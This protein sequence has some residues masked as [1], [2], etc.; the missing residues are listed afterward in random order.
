MHK[1]ALTLLVGTTTLLASLRG[2]AETNSVEQRLRDT[3]T[4][5]STH[6]SR[7]AG[8]P[9]DRFAADLVEREL[10]A[11]GVEG[12]RREPYE[13]VVPIDHGASLQVLREEGGSDGGDQFELKSLWP[14][15]VRT[16]TLGPQGL[17]GELIYAG[18]GEYVDFN[19][20]NVQGSVV[21]MEFNSGSNWK[22][23]AA[24]GAA[25]IIFVEPGAT[26][27]VESRKKWSWAPVD[28]PRFWIDGDAATALRQRMRGADG[29]RVHLQAR[30]DWESVTTWNIWGQVPGTDPALAD[31]LVAVQASYDG[32]S[33]VPADNPA[34][35]SA[36]SIAALLEFA[37]Y[38][39]DHPPG[40]SV[41]LLATGSNFLGK[42]GVFEFFDRHA[43]MEPLFKNRVPKRLVVDKIDTRRLTAAAQVRGLDLDSLGVF[44]GNAREPGAGPA[45]ESVDI[46][47]LTAQLK[48]RRLDPDSLGVPL[49][50]DSLAIA[51]FIGLDLSSHGS[52]VGLLQSTW[53]PELRRIFVPLGRSFTRYAEAFGAGRAGLI[54]LISP[55]KGLTAASYIAVDAGD[56]GAAARDVGI[57]ALNLVTTTDAR[58]VLDT[59]LDTHDKVDFNYLGRQSETINGVLHRALAD[60]ALF[61][62]RAAENRRSHEKNLPD[63]R[64]AIDGRLRL[65]PIRGATPDDPVPEA[66]VSV[67]DDVQARVWRPSLYLADEE[68][69]YQIGARNFSTE[70][71]GFL[72]DKTTGDIVYATDMGERAQD[73]GAYK[74]TPS[75]EATVWMTILFPVESMEIHERI[76]A[77]RH[78]TFGRWDDDTKILDQRGGKPRQYGFGVGTWGEQ[79]LVLFGAR[80]DSLR[81]VEQSLFLLDNE[82]A[83][84]EIEA[85]GRGFDLS[86]HKMLPHASL[87]SAVD[88]WRIDE[89]RIERMRKFAIEN[90][91]V[92]A[93]HE[94][95]RVAL[96]RAV[97]AM[98]ALDWGLYIKYIREALGYEYRAYPDV[99]GTQS[100]VMNGLVFF[101]ALLIPAA[102]FSERLIFASTDIRRQLALC[103]LITLIVWIILAQVHPAFGLAHPI[104][105][106]LAL[107]VLGTALFVMSLIA[108]RFNGFMDEL[109]ES[110]TGTV[111]GDI[112]RAGT[113]YA[114]FM[115]GISNMRRRAL[116]TCLT[117]GTITILTFTVLSFTSAKQA[118]R[119]VGFEKD[120]KPAYAGVLVHDVHWWPLEPTNLAFLASHFGEHGTIAARSWLSMGWRQG[121]G[122]MPIRRGDLEAQAL[123]VM[124]LTAIE[125]AL[126]GLD[127]ALTA[128]TWFGG[129]AQDEGIMLSNHLAEQLGIRSE[130]IDGDAERADAP[131]VS[132]L[133]RSWTVVGLFDG[134]IYDS[135]RDLNNEPITPAKQRFEQFNLPGMDRLLAS[136]NLYSAANIDIGVEHMPA[137]RLAILPFDRMTEMGVALSSVAIALN[138]PN[139]ARELVESYLARAAFRLFVAFPDDEGQQHTYAYTS[140]S[141]TGM[142]GFG[143]L[144]I[145]LL[146]A[147]LIVLNTMM[148]AVYERFREIGVYSS[149]G[150]APVHIA[151]LFIAE[152]CVYGILGITLGYIVGQVGAKLLMAYDL[153]SGVSLNYSSTSAIAAAVLVMVVVVASTLYPAKVA[154]RMAVPDV[155][156]RWQLPDPEEDIWQFDF[157]F[158]ANAQ[159]IES[160]CG[161]LHTYFCAYGHE[162]VGKMYTEKTRIV[163]SEDGRPDG[164]PVYSVQLLLWLAP[165][166]MGVSEY[167]QFTMAP[168]DIQGIYG[169]KLYIE[170]ISGPLAFW[171][172]LNLRFM[173][174]L[175]KQFLV[176]QTLGDEMQEQYTT[177]AREVTT[178]DTQLANED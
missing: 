143:N 44:L 17:N 175:R 31:E 145:P 99:K 12:V 58:Y 49:E 18:A 127:R 126:T 86:A 73:I 139:T 106:L 101:V 5:L 85:Q 170:R 48:L 75:K 33:V 15:L 69:N 77:H 163:V 47:R 110:R 52:Q 74:Q 62:P 160:L 94:R 103:G 152:A 148:G 13:V 140:L 167:L 176:W 78:W 129:K 135:I 132:L 41:A 125:P 165:F 38:L 116:R 91:R 23:A 72:L 117:L 70:V 153:L 88:M 113:A 137:T 16:N 21:L 133:G 20:E 27:P 151:F 56:G 92:N 95:A 61:G 147:A 169:I 14:N 138:E 7:L 178:R 71:T 114:A 120:W 149:V 81:L 46:D 122:F 59:P 37:R 63:V 98:E 105:V 79:M 158:T 8:Y 82:G 141:V 68:G 53:L 104:I 6:G 146:I 157:P 102:F 64:V 156:R 28:V 128:G 177:H 40:R 1:T 24:L 22:N 45:F 108:G 155:V 123:G 168:S 87:Q 118:I 174:E 60:P 50:P 159:A 173:L 3:V 26:S 11:A 54:N 109:R 121:D 115:L 164:K 144:V 39:K 100:D 55:R 43:R 142:E 124:G 19:G 80:G 93:L 35:E 119:F 30:M 136:S 25:A 29:L 130:Q 171:Q 107:M 65:L 89:L 84:D 83:R 36:A 2:D 112:S 66:I 4:A 97:S 34:A 10:I 96:E 90:P 32:M 111:E 166:D 131:R 161:Y 42:K 9:G 172:R 150:L 154:A 51:L 76:H 57:M 67:V 162:S 134:E